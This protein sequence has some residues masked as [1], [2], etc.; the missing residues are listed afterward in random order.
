MENLVIAKGYSDCICYINENSA[1]VVVAATE[2]GLTDSDT[3]R[4]AEIV[5]DETDLSVGQIKIIETNP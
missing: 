1:S 2:T 4:I 5:M 3:A